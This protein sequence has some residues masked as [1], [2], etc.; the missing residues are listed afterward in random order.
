[1]PLA[2]QR[3]RACPEISIAFLVL[4]LLDGRPS[5]RFSAEIVVFAW[6]LRG[7]PFAIWREGSCR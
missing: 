3:F 7:L 5:K 2:W 1:M 6:F 4:A